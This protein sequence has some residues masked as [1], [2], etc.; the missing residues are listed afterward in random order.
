MQTVDI[1]EHIADIGGRKLQVI[2]W[3]GNSPKLDYRTWYE[4]GTKPG[5]GICLSFGEAYELMGTLQEYFERVPSPS[6][7]KKGD[8]YAGQS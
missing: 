1:Q 2:S 4:D 5:K 7:V 3:G 8:L 6:G